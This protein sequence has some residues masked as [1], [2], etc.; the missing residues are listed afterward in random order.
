M[1]IQNVGGEITAFYSLLKQ[2]KVLVKNYNFLPA[3]AM[4]QHSVMIQTLVK[5][6]L[7]NLLQFFI[8]CIYYKFIPK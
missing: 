5:Y 2:L 7:V 1:T 4:E 8:N 6:K 3:N